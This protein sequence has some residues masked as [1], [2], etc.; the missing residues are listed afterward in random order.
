M[1][2]TDETTDVDQD[3]GPEATV[4]VHLQHVDLDVHAM[5]ELV[6]GLTVLPGYSLPSKQRLVRSMKDRLL[7]VGLLG[8]SGWS[9][10]LEPKVVDKA[11]DQAFVL[12]YRHF[13]EAL[14]PDFDGP[15]TYTER[16]TAWKDT[17][18][19][20]QMRRY[21]N[22]K[23]KMFGETGRRTAAVKKAGRGRQKAGGS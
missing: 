20:E 18:D 6:A 23:L 13:R 8:L 12:V 11:R 2:A 14:L 7:Q 22:G 10:G 17:L 15:V 5:I 19:P 4:R 9:F 3:A 1:V 21:V 16:L